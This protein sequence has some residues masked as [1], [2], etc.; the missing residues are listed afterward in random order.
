M[1]DEFSFAK[2][3]K[4]SSRSK[5]FFQTFVKMARNISEALAPLNFMSKFCG[6]SIFSINRFDFS[7]GFKRIDVLFQIWIVV[8]NCFL[9]FYLWDA[10]QS[11]PLHKSDIISKSLPII[12]CGCFGLYIVCVIASIALR[13]KQSILMKSIF[14]IDEMV[15]TFPFRLWNKV[16]EYFWS[17][18]ILRLSSIMRG[19]GGSWFVQFYQLLL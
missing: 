7:I 10:S 5:T 9:N 13:K 6:Y 17:L 18:K 16:D 8:V 4:E 19:N 14:A 11:F 1:L 3:N 12:L 15:R 2:K